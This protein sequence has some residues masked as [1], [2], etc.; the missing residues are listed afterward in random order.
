[1]HPL[2]QHDS[3]DVLHPVPHPRHCARR[4]SEGPFEDNVDPYRQVHGDDATT[5][6]SEDDY[7]GSPLFLKDAVSRCVRVMIFVSVSL[8]IFCVLV[9]LHF[10]PPPL[11]TDSRTSL[12]QT[13]LT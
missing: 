12:V 8:L 10:F 11:L 7:A 13:L 3:S 2:F 1:M 4:R 9:T 5:F 6:A